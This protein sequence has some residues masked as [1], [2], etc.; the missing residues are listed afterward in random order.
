M[1]VKVAEGGRLG[2]HDE[3]GLGIMDV[4]LLRV[5]DGVRCTVWEA[6]WVASMELVTDGVPDAATV[7]V[8]DTL[9][10][11][12]PVG[13]GVGVSVG[14][15]L[16]VGLVDGVGVGLQVPEGVLDGEVEGVRVDVVVAV[17]LRER[18]A[19]HVALLVAVAVGEPEQVAL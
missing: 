8:L 12:V 15:R 9:A 1:P 4:V 16:V 5:E 2:L 7:V 11:R 19:V 17:G 18:E 14:E 13:L 6:V 3:V 10:E